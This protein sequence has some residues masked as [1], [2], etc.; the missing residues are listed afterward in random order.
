MSK[1]KRMLKIIAACEGLYL[2]EVME[3][4]LRARYPA[5]FNG[6]I[7]IPEQANRYIDMEKIGEVVYSQK[8]GVPRPMSALAQYK[9]EVMQGTQTRETAL[10]HD[11]IDFDIDSELDIWR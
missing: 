1:I 3:E 8:N 10:L 7:R 9:K 4:A 11:F 6:D 5:Y 2:S